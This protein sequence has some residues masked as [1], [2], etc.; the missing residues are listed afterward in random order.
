MF[1]LLWNR[2]LFPIRQDGNFFEKKLNSEE[3]VI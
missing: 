2:T 1:V 3:R